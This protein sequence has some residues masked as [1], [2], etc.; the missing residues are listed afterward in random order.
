[1]A[2][3]CEPAK[4]HDLGRALELLRQEKLPE[5]GVVEQFGHFLVVREDTQLIGVCGIEIQGKYGLLRSVAVDPG[6]RDTGVGDCLV[7]GAVELA[8][9]KLKLTA[10]YLLTTTAERYFER[11]GFHATA[12]DEAPA[13]VRESWEFRVGCPETAVL[14]RRA[15]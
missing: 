11:Y 4:P 6:F 12:R 9:D 5:G 10:L 8:S 14:M 15:L 1:V 13:E 2:Y 3:R 7:R